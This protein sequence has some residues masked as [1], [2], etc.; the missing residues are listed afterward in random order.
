MSCAATTAQDLFLNGSKISV[1]VYYAF[2]AMIA[3]P[4]SEMLSFKT[5]IVFAVRAAPRVYD[6]HAPTNWSEGIRQNWDGKERV[7]P[8]A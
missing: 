2:D 5:E 4:T 7:G 6:C 1:G 3:C 8:P